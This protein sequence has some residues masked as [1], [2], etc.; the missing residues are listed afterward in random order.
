ME[1]MRS[2]YLV[3]RRHE[4][5]VVTRHAQ[6]FKRSRREDSADIFTTSSLLSLLLSILF[7]EVFLHDH[8]H[9]FTS[10]S[11]LPLSSSSITC[12]AITVHFSSVPPCLELMLTLTKKGGYGISRVVGYK[13]C[14]ASICLEACESNNACEALLTRPPNV[15]LV[16]GVQIS[17]QPSLA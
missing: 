3:F 6:V 11:L 10:V 8:N 13:S 14:K 7:V 15:V 9:F 4:Q 17:L 1:Q 5:T 2:C 12:F 16:F